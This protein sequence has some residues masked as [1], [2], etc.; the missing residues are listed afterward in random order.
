MK[1]LLIS[2]QI[3]GKNM[4]WIIGTI[5]YIIIGS[6]LFNICLILFGK[7]CLTEK[8]EENMV[9]IIA[10]WPIFLLILLGALIANKILKKK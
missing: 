3:W 5:I 2:S 4:S 10:L 7:D 8:E 6:V 1:K 9:S